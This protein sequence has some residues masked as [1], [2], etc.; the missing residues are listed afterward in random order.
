SLIWRRIFTIQTGTLFSILFAVSF[1]LVRRWPWLLPW[2]VG[3][4]VT[5]LAVCAG[6]LRLRRGTPGMIAGVGAGALL[7][8][9]LWSAGLLSR[10]GL[11]QTPGGIAIPLKESEKRLILNPEL[12]DNDRFVDNR[13]V[14]AVKSNISD[15]KEIL[16][17][18]RPDDAYRSTGFTSQINSAINLPYPQTRIAAPQT[19]EIIE[20]DVKCVDA[21]GRE[22]GPWSFSF[23]P[24][25]ELFKLW[26]LAILTMNMRRPWVILRG[27]F[28]VDGNRSFVLATNFML[29]YT[30]L[31]EA[32]RSIVYGLDTEQPD[33]VIDIDSIRDTEIAH[34]RDEEVHYVTSYLIF[35][36][37]TSSDIRRANIEM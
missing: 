34:I 19:D 16:Y 25:D 31:R 22:Y 20:I 24:G 9:L 3:T 36:D 7:F 5:A 21:G 1:E 13:L 4:S 15:L 30:Y 12:W 8:T 27:P 14:L 11:I 28:Y 26:K 32:V 33:T 18:I 6:L 37:G 35:K 17:R 10:D 23:D 29:L 2:T